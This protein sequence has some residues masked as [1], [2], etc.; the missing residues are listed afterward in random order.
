M[1]VECTGM[2]SNLYTRGTGLSR[3]PRCHVDQERRA[4]MDLAIGKSND[5]WRPRAWDGVLFMYAGIVVEEAN[6]ADAS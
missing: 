1:A 6:G 3:R 2:S 4:L 5:K